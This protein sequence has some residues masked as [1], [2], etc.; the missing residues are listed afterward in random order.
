MGARSLNDAAA[1]LQRR[2][3][4]QAPPE[5]RDSIVVKTLRKA[6]QRVL[7]IEY[8][9]RAENHV[10]AALEYPRGSGRSE[11]LEPG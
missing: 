6:D 4:A 5:L 7:S 3:R 10:Y 9:D 8:D 1:D 11:S 2:I